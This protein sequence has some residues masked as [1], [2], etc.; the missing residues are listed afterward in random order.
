MRCVLRNKNQIFKDKITLEHQV[1]I[2]HVESLKY[3]LKIGSQKIL[4]LSYDWIKWYEILFY[5][6][7]EDFDRQLNA[8]IERFQSLYI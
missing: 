2:M 7:V 5:T 8:D 4:Y 3:I 6:F 1:V